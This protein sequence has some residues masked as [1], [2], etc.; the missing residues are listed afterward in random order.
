MQMSRTDRMTQREVDEF[1]V[2]ED[3]YASEQSSFNELKK[4]KRQVSHYKTP[5][6]ERTLG[7]SMTSLARDDRSARPDSQQTAILNEEARRQ[8]AMLEELAHQMREEKRQ[9]Q[10]DKEMIEREKI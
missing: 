8:V 9:L 10:L 6:H 5:G 2:D 7:G 3:S 1:G 4:D